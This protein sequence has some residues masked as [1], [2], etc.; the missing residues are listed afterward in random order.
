MTTFFAT[1]SKRAAVFAALFLLASVPSFAQP[2]NI[3]GTDFKNGLSQVTGAQNTY[4]DISPAGLQALINQ[5]GANQTWSFQGLPFVLDTTVINDNGTIVAY[6]PSFPEAASF[7]TGTH[8]ETS[9]SGGITSYY[10]FEINQQLEKGSHT[11]I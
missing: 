7:P 2:L 4:N 3:S 6:S 8:V 1:P 10:F 9:T 11:F 5:T